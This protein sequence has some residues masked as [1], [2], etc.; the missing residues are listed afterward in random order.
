MF[1]VCI[2]LD[3]LGFLG[4]HYCWHTTRSIKTHA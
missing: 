2:T 4:W 3:W 1:S